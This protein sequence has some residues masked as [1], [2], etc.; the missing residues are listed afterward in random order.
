MY[1]LIV[2][3]QSKEITQKLLFLYKAIRTVK[4][5][6]YSFVNTFIVPLTQDDDDE[7]FVVRTSED[8]ERQDNR[9]FR[10]L[11]VGS[12]AHFPSISHQ[13]NQ[14]KSFR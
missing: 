13:R 7:F 4:V 12:N 3:S 14:E 9:R 8:K 5:F 11:K 1:Y 10:L 6:I 2:Q